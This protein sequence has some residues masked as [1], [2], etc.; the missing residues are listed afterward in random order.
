MLM[1]SQVWGSS[2]KRKT[3]GTSLGRSCTSSLP[4]QMWPP[5]VPILCPVKRW[6]GRLPPF[7]P[8]SLVCCIGQRNTD[9]NF[10]VCGWIGGDQGM[11]FLS[12]RRTGG[13]PH[14][15]AYSAQ[16]C[17]AALFPCF[18]SGITWGRGRARVGK[19]G[20]SVNK[21]MM[22][23]CWAWTLLTRILPP[24]LCLLRND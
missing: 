10:L 4:L 13:L 11:P 21:L 15:P 3:C 22:Q 9:L 14:F 19:S 8:I 6:Q 18:W 7:S 16:L 1:R 20:K 24:K 12:L 17:A 5:S 2:G 23:S